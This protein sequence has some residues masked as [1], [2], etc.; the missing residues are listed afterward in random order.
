MKH[1]A[2][3]RATGC[4]FSA[5]AAGIARSDKQTRALASEQMRNDLQLLTGW[6]PGKDKR[7]A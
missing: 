3:I 2:T 7:A 5:L 4:A 1:T 6:V